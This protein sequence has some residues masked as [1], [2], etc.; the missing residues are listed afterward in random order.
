VA[1]LPRDDTR[2]YTRAIVKDQLVQLFPDISSRSL[3]LN[4]WYEDDIAGDVSYT[5]MYLCVI[6]IIA[7]LAI[8]DHAVII[9]GTYLIACATHISQR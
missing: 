7:R 8:F 5:Y 4:L 6:I 9:L 2:L 1:I 3:K